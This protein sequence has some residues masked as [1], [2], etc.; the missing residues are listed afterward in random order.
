MHLL[1]T[2]DRAP[3]LQLAVR[4][5]RGVGPGQATHIIIT[6]NHHHRT[7]SLLV[8]ADDGGEES[9]VARDQVGEDELEPSEVIGYN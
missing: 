3:Q 6:I 4:L 1:I 2:Q 8:D 7:M 5:G 9:G